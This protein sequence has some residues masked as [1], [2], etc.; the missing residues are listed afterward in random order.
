[1]TVLLLVSSRVKFKFKFKFEKYE[2]DTFNFFSCLINI[3][4]IVY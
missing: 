2:F 1:M 4:N 3:I